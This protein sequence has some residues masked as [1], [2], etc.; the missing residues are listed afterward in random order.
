MTQESATIEG[1][2]PKAIH[3][4]H[5]NMCKFNSRE[6]DNYRRVAPRLEQ[7]AIEIDSNKKPESPG[8]VS[9]LMILVMIG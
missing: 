5:I 3:A 8:I 6:D 7:W 4:D 2:R 9:S 1:Y